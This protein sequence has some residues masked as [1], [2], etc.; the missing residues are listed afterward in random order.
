MPLDDRS[1]HR[2]R[3]FTVRIWAEAVG[4]GMEQRGR[5]RDVT[6]GA[7]RNFREWSDLTKFLTA[8]IDEERDGQQS[9]SEERS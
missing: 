1:H 4:D 3:L 8:Q 2:S 9:M 7:F 6:S 5:V